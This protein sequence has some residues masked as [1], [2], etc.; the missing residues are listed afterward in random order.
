MGFGYSLFKNIGIYLAP[1]FEYY[2]YTK[3]QPLS[4]KTDNPFRFNIKAGLK[5]DF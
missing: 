3:G 2:F 4:Y 1:E 5:F